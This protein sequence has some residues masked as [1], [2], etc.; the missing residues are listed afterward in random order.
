MCVHV[1]YRIIPK[2]GETDI[3]SIKIETMVRTKI[4][5]FLRSI[6]SLDPQLGRK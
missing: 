6:I 3:S 1:G 5:S 4:S 2:E